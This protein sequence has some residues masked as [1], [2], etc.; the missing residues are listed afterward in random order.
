MSKRI[1]EHQYKVNVI[2]TY[3]NNEQDIIDVVVE[4]EYMRK[5][6]KEDFLKMIIVGVLEED[7]FL[8]LTVISTCIYGVGKREELPNWYSGKFVKEYGDFSSLSP[9]FSKT[10]LIKNGEMN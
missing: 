10:P 7:E 5:L 1:K 3:D 6:S 8:Q 4:K 2:F 9:Y